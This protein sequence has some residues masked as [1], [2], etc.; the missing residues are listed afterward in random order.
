MLRR[1]IY[2]VIIW[3]IYR[4]LAATWRFR[5]IEP[6]SLQKLRKAGQAVVF[7]HWHGDELVLVNLIPRYRIAT[8]VSTSKDGEMMSTL[9]K[10]QRGQSSR[11]SSS[12]KAIQGLK[13][14]IR[15]MN[16]GHMAS[17][18][19]DGPKGPRHSVK[20]GVFEISRV[21]KRP[22]FVAGCACDRA[23]HFPKSWNKTYLPKPFARVIV[24]W[25][26]PHGPVEK[27]QDAKSPKLKSDLE[28]ALGRA[29][30]DAEAI[31]HNGPKSSTQD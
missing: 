22:I 9:I 24:Y 11:G 16:K 21:S 27:G 1:Y 31:L 12:K 29:Q 2:P 26:G 7:A 14:L 30:T 25:E 17:L 4:C 20:P 15:L 8:I 10:L 13:G 23:W 6:E 3:I 28:A 19:V 18:A 5:V